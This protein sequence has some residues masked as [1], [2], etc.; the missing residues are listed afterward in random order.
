MPLRRPN[1]ARASSGV[2]AE[3]TIEVAPPSPSMANPFSAAR[4]ESSRPWAPVTVILR[5]MRLR[6]LPC[7]VFPFLLLLRLGG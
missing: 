1:C 5:R 2:A 7:E 6:G 3:M 4:R